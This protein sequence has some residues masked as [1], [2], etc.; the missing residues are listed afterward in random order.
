MKR[1][2]FLILVALILSLGISAYAQDGAVLINPNGGTMVGPNIKLNSD[3][4]FTVVYDNTTGERCNVS[5]GFKVTS[6]D[7]L[8][9]NNVK[10]DTLPPDP[11]GEAFLRTYF[12]QAFAV[13]TDN[14]TVG[15]LGAG[16]PS[17]TRQLPLGPTTMFGL[18]IDISTVGNVNAQADNGKHLCIDTADG[19]D[20]LWTWK[21]VTRTLVDKFPTYSVAGLT[22][23]SQCFVVEWVLNQPPA[24]SNPPAQTETGVYCSTFSHQFTA[25]DP[26]GDPITGF[27]LV[28]GPGAITA[29]GMWSWNGATI[30]DVGASITVVVEACDAG[31]CGADYSMAVSV[32]N[33]APAITNSCPIN[34]G[35]SSTGSTKTVDLDGTDD[36]GVLL[37]SVADDGDP[38]TTVSIDANGVL[39]FSS[40]AAGLFAQTVTLSDGA[41]SVTCVVNFEVSANSAY[42]VQ[43]EKTHMTLQGGFENVDV[44]LNYMHPINGIGGFNILI[45]YDN[46]ALSLQQVIEGS[47]YAA[48]GWEYFTYRFGADGNCSGGCPSGLVRVIG[49]AETNNGANHPVADCDATGETLFSLKFLVSND[50]TLECQYAPIRFFWLD[51]GDNTIS[52]ET[53]NIL[54][55]AARVYDYHFID[56]NVPMDPNL[57]TFPGYAGVPIGA[58][59]NSTPGKPDPIRDIDF[60]NGGIDIACVDSIDDRG[61]VNLNDFAYEIADAV[62][63][64]RYF[65][66]GLPVFTINQAGQIASTDANADGLV[67]TVADL[68][69]LI[70]VVVGDELPYDKLSAVSTEFTNANGTLS[71]TGDMGAALVVVKGN[72]VPENLTSSIMDFAFDG[73]NTRILVYPDVNNFA[74]FTGE[75]LNVNNAEVVS[76]EFGSANGATVVAKQIPANFSLN[77]NY[78]NPFN[79]ETVI[80]FALPNA[81]DYT[82]TIYN[83]TG[84]KVAEFSGAAEAGIE[85][86]RWNATSNASGIYFYKLNAGSFSATKKMVLIK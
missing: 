30:G 43:I 14:D 65:V 71:V 22:T 53:G 83:V 62:L 39:S 81:S 74:S 69:Y 84:Q 1:N 18:N 29:G 10:L 12:N 9:I 75:F 52:D 27:N 44:T 47:I 46:S 73:T 40:T 7:G 36:C 70:R 64:S 16:N 58:C 55:I 60:Y 49:I 82:L 35:F 67:L 85:E 5:N 77:Q 56:A 61:D 11:G 26:E 13:Q 57:A 59:E 80:S 20:G 41:L 72:V 33:A 31:G 21:W 38:A 76:V 86:V 17:G 68:V 54:Y 4:A 15:C 23:T 45:A 51:C 24:I 50:Y 66:Y 78:P 63:F 25:V 42:G 3:P 32:T 48:C 79:P 6:P 8:A 28:S 19:N 2:S 37:W 34:G